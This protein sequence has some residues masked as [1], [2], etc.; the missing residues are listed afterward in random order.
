MSYDILK[1]EC[2]MSAEENK[3]LNRRFFDEFWDRKNLTVADELMAANHV[4]YTPGTPPLPPGPE[5]FK[6]FATVF[7][8]AFPDLRVMIEDQIAEGDR[9]A[10]RWSSTGTNTGSLMGIPP[11]GKSI[12]VTGITITRI[13]GGKATETWTNFD[14]LGLLQQIGVAPAP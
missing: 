8:S 10:T 11:T 5:G 3:A 6:Q 14:M 2:C 4:N 1:G 7:M 12:N 13:V 9:V